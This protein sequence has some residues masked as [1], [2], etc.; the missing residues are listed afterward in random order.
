MLLSLKD[1]VISAFGIFSCQHEY[2]GILS[3]LMQTTTVNVDIDNIFFVLISVL[4]ILLHN[5]EEV[6]QTLERHS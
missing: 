3:T 4:R 5:L 1:G 6:N 2:R